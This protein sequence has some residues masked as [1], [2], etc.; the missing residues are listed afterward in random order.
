MEEGE[1]EEEEEEEVT[2]APSS[3][4][5]AE[6]PRDVEVIVEYKKAFKVLSLFH[7]SAEELNERIRG[8]ELSVESLGRVLVPEN[9]DLD[10]L[11]SAV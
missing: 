1:D 9:T 4:S 7:Y 5:E 11:A 8:T 2:E 10:S 6:R 3:P